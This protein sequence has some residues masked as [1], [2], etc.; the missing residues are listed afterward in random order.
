[1]ATGSGAGAGFSGSVAHPANATAAAMSSAVLVLTWFLLKS[2]LCAT[3]A[4]EFKHSEA[5]PHKPFFERKPML[6]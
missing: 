3:S 2:C 4:G 6:A 5:L 1:L